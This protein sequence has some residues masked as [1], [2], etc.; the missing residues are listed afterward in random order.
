M[1]SWKP[2]HRANEK[3]NRLP[4]S[5]SRRSQGVLQIAFTI[6][7]EDAKLLRLQARAQKMLFFSRFSEGSWPVGAW[8]FLVDILHLWFGP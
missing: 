8:I 4:H 5:V 2:P 6:L 7:C 3:V 1:T